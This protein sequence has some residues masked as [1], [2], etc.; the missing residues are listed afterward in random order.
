[1]MEAHTKLTPLNGENYH[2]WKGKMKDLLFVKNLHLPVFA[3]N[4]PE[5]KSNEEWDFEHQQVCGFI[6]QFFDD[7]VYNFVANETH[8]RSLWDKLESLYASK[9]GTNKLYLLKN[10]VELKYKEGTSVSNHLSE[11]QGRYDQLAGVGIK[12]DD[13]L[14]GLFLLN[15]LPDS[16]ETFRVSMISATPNGDI[17]LQMAKSGALNEEMRRKTQGTLSHSEVLI[18][19]NRGRS[20]KKENSGKDKSRSKSK[21]RYKNVECHY[22]HKTGH[23]KKNCFLW[24]KESKD[25]KGKQKEKDNDD[26]DCVTTTTCGDLVCL[27]DYDTINFVS[28]ESMW[29]I[30]S[31]ATLHVTSRKEFFTSYTPG[32]FGVLK[33]GNDGVS[34]VI[35]VGDVHLQTNMGMQLLLRGVKHAPDVR[36][37]LIFV[38]ILDDGGFD[39]HFGS[40]KW[41]LTKGNLIVAKGEKNS[42]L[43]WTKA[44]VAK[45]SV[46]VVY[47]ESSLWHRRLGHISEKGLNCLAK[48]DVLSRLKNVELEKCS[49]C[50][51]GKQ[52]RVSFRKH[53]PSRKSELLELVHSDV[54]GLLKVKSFSGAL[55]FVTFIYDCSRKLW[56][57]A[58]Q[59]KDQVLDK[60]KEFHALVER[61]SGKKLKRI[62]TDNG[63][64]YCGPFDAYCRQY[65]IAHEKTPPKTPQLNGLAERMNK[66]LIERVRCMLSEA[67]LPKHFWGEALFTA[68]HV[69]NLSPAVALNSEVPDKIW[70]SKNVT[71]DHLRVF[72]CKAFV[73]HV[74]KDERSKLDV[75]TRQC[76]FIG[77]GQDEFGYKLY[78]P[79][80]KKV[81]RSRDVQFMEDQTIED[82][83][84]VEKSTPK[85]DGNV[86]DIDPIRL[87]IN[88]LDIDVHDDEQHGDIDNQ[89]VG[90]SLNVPIDNVDEEEHDV[91]Q[92]ESLGDVTELPEAQP[93]RSDRPK[94]PSK[95]YSSNEY[96]MLTDEGEPECYEEAIESE[97]K[98]KWLD[99]MQD[100]MKSLH[101]NHTYDLVKLLWV[102]KFLQELGFVQDKYL[103]YCDSQSA[104]HLGKNPTFHSKSKHIDVRYH[105]ILDVLDVKLLELA[106]VHTD[107]NGAD[108]MTKA[109]PRGKFE[110]CCEIAGLADIST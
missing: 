20:Q 63:G 77:F 26:G 87:S 94:Q 29:I 33:M 62:R 90:D 72:G 46:N 56:V 60:F 48:K 31:G 7:N 42:K 2:L 19:E 50:M 44:L 64:E 102:K 59:R 105:W 6:R 57:Y 15:S 9:S 28:D 11:F 98:Q 8:A 23:I 24:K 10:F 101:D 5:S 83:D 85:E 106:K 71:Y 69:I 4:K 110:V 81:V 22:C 88:D 107:D 78:D 89:Q 79:I 1:M 93:R 36:F 58:L 91:S 76:I 100:E 104:I 17:S 66:T 27:R 61:Q 68:V 55:Y 75:K 43:Y 47:M 25:K 70:F 103:L 80:E 82:I 49:H 34:K 40:G 53:P 45:D 97:E 54:C 96:V 21:S 37:N 52:T 51:A 38:Q 18:T 86:T 95:R 73:V 65:G 39:N 99:A 14:L 84:K 109:L 41:K 108:M 16:W 30:D 92:D 13:D 32:D 74:P 35:G 67:K 12:F 3:S